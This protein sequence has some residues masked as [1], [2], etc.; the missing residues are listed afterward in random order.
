MRRLAQCVLLTVNYN[1]MTELEILKKVRAEM[2]PN[3]KAGEY[4]LPVILKAMHEF[5]ALR[6]PL[7]SGPLPPDDVL[8]K[9]VEALDEYG[10]YVDNY[11]YGL[12][13]DEEHITSMVE[14]CKKVIGGNDR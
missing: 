5:A 3:A 9:L 8:L 7:V 1:R 11:D 13:T 4:D 2:N 14:I 6:Q 12:P 10:R